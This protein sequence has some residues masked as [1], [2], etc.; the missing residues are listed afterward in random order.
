MR[1]LEALVERVKVVAPVD[2]R[3]ERAPPRDVR[4]EPAVEDGAVAVIMP[5]LTPGRRLGHGLAREPTRPET[6]PIT[7]A[8]GK[9]RRVAGAVAGYICDDCDA[10]RVT[11]KCIVG[12]RQRAASPRHSEWR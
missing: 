12:R 7:G 6:R 8:I 9:R 5:G 2:R 4:R 10:L 1:L 11:A 3:A